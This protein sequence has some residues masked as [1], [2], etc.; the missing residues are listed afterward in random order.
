MCVCPYYLRP[1]LALVS[2][3]G[4]MDG[5]LKIFSAFLYTVIEECPIQSNFFVAELLKNFLK[6]ALDTVQHLEQRS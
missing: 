4:P 5:I 6:K 2:C 3:P 1:L